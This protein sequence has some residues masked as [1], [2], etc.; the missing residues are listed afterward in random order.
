MPPTMASIC[1]SVSMPPALR[2]KAGI[3]VPG[4]P[5]R[6][7]RRIASSSAMARNRGSRKGWAAP[8]VPAGPGRRRDFRRRRS[9]SADPRWRRFGASSLLRLPGLVREAGRLDPGA[10]GERG[11]LPGADPFLPGDDDSS[12]D[13]ESDLRGHEPEPID[14]RVENGIDEPDEAVEQ[15]DPE[16]RNGEAREEDRAAREDGEQRSVQESDQERAQPM[17]EASEGE[18]PRL[19]AADLRCRLPDRAGEEAGGQQIDR[20]PDAVAR[21]DAV[22]RGDE[23]HRDAPGDA[24]TDS[25]PHRIDLDRQPGAAGAAHHL[26]VHDLAAQGHRRRRQWLCSNRLV[27]LDR[28]HRA[29]PAD[30]AGHRGHG[31]EQADG[32]AGGE[33]GE[34]E[35]DAE[36]ADQGPC[37][38]GGNLDGPWRV[39]AFDFRPDFPSHGVLPSA[40][41]DV[42]D[43]EHGDPDDV[44]E[45]PVEREHVG[46]GRV[47]LLDL[48]EE[49]EERDRPEGQQARGE[50]ERVQADQRVVGGPEEVRPDGQALVDD[51]VPPFQP[52]AGQE[53]RSERDSREPPAR[54]GTDL[55]APERRHRPMD[56]PA[57][58][59]QA[60][61]E[62][63]GRVQ[64][65]RSRPARALPHVEEVGDDEDDEDRRLRGDQREHA[66]P[67]SRGKGPGNRGAGVAGG[68]GAHS[69][70][71][72][73]SSGCLRSHKGRRLFT[74]GMV[75]K[76]YS[77]GGEVVDHSSV[78]ASHGSL[79][80]GRPRNAERIR[81][82]TKV[83]TP[84]A[85]KTTPTAMITFQT[86]QPRPG[87]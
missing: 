12:D 81:L 58:R 63:D 53:H 11:G 30:D 51:Q 57:A 15:G 33:P 9:G 52:G 38:R 27:R 59:E 28:Q 87:S 6:T 62:E 39:L 5:L 49:R 45:V 83:R 50:V 66:D 20:V 65:R 18:R 69:Y 40:T 70:F 44:D 78:H 29:E 34:Y 23:R 10:D 43:E 41:D 82:A 22:Q 64:H 13:S 85:W 8:P 60:D 80:A 46:V 61:G 67:S 16:E 7:T 71:Q 4:T 19:E 73:G 42:D 54:E 1:S 55:S 72:S 56:R 2:A 84:A 37:R 3:A 26:Q 79:P 76:L 24:A 36:G 75:A 68:G 74:V 48:S 31:A 21:D 77:G 17:N 32:R 86:S 14:A 25:G 47:L 35:G